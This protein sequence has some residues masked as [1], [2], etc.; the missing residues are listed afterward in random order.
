ME[1][2]VEFEKTFIFQG[3]DG[4]FGVIMIIFDDVKSVENGVF[5]G[6]YRSEYR[7]DF[8]SFLR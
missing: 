3:F 5:N 1:F 4:V 2:S 7:S 6:F 8:G